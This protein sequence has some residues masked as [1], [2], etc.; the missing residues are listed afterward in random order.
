[1]QITKSKLRNI[2]N[3]EL[4]TILGEGWFGGSPAPRWVRAA[5][6]LSVQTQRKAKNV[7]AGSRVQPGYKPK[8]PTDDGGLKHMTLP[9]GFETKGGGAGPLGGLTKIAD[10]AI[11][12]YADWKE[13]EGQELVDPQRR[14]S[15]DT[16][17]VHVSDPKHA[18]DI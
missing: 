9:A 3:E 10:K 8:K 18:E 13:A 7:G 5:R 12:A 15:G 11:G 16:K 14:A 2:I 4:E 17:I 6:E 1:M